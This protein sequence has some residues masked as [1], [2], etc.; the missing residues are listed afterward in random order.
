[1]QCQNLTA[2]IDRSCRRSK[3]RKKRTNAFT[4]ISTASLLSAKMLPET[5]KLKMKTN[6]SPSNFR[7]QELHSG[8]LNKPQ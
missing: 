8:K 4:P 7:T 6:S 1:M 3:F 2:K 5:A